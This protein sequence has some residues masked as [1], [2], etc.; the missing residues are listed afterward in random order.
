MRPRTARGSCLGLL[1]AR[2]A[3]ACRLLAVCL[4]AP[5]SL[6]AQEGPRLRGVVVDVETGVPVGGAEVL[7]QS[8]PFRVTTGADGSFQVALPDGR[9]YT[10]VVL[11]SGFRPVE[12]NVD[13]ASVAGEPLRITMERLLFDVPGLTVT[14]SRR[15]ARPGAAPT[16]VAV[17][18][19]DELERR[20]V[21]NLKEALPFAQGVTFNAGHMDIRGSS[22]IARGVGSR[23]LMLLDGHR[24]LGGVGSDIDFGVLPLLDIE[25]IEIVKG[26]HST[27]WGT[28]AMGGVVNVIT[29]APPGGQRTVVRGYYG[30]FDTPGELDFSEER[31]NM[32]GIELQH[33]RRIGGNDL[34]LSVAREG[35]DGFRQNGA[36]GR[37]RLRFKTVFGPESA[38]PWEVFA[39]WKRQ[40][41]E[42]F[43]TWLS[44]DR[45]LEVDPAALGDYKRDADL[46]VGLTAIPLLTSRLKLQIRPQLQHVRSQNYFHDNAD[47]HRSTRYGT[48]AQLTVFSGGR[49]ALTVGGDGAYTTVASNFLSP[50]PAVT[51]LALFAQDE[52]ELSDRMRASVGVRLDSHRTS[53]VEDDLTLSPKIGLV[54]QPGERVSLRTSF[55]RGYR[56]PSVSEQFTSTTV[57]GFRVIPNLEIRGESAWAGEVGATASPHDRIWLDA[58]LFWSEYAGL[59]E[60]GAAPNQYFTF[61]F[62]NVSEARVR[63]ID[64]GVRVGLVPSKLNLHAN[65]M[66]VDS[67]DQ[68]TGRHLAYRSR[69]NLTTTL[70]GW[71]DVIAVDVRHRSRPDQV[72]VYP[73]DERGAITLLDLRM[74]VTIMDMDVHAKIANLLQT[75]YVDVQER[76]PGATR[77][78]RFTV[79]SRF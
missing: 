60:V 62:Q 21:T 26:P 31:L 73:L 51:D 3:V 25:R 76:N 42:E 14:A 48:D 39:S 18:G 1:A 59:I 58:G 72:L 65:Y 63:G 61:Q 8:T 13:A 77:S 49:H 70:S 52:I 23:V 6:V 40:E 66:Y 45:R 2:A 32:D 34:T 29:R 15:A 68:Q 43:F 50:T 22:G 47:F 75:E 7:V 38:T 56:A 53:F 64:T 46:I 57:F 16:S 24:V 35:S 27:L 71:S 67:K 11:A 55:S 28:N 69:H 20:N 44:A 10:L 37:W 12:R 5:L 33:S 9:E 41:A 74:A 4:L 17:I 19:A 36:M 78:V 54:Y 30:V 79:T